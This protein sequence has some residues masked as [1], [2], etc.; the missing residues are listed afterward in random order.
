MIVVPSWLAGPAIRVLIICSSQMALM[1][2]YSGS[3]DLQFPIGTYVQLFGFC[4][5]VK[6]I[7]FVKT[8]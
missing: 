4:S 3:D 8:S 2:N 7:G 1:S 5:V 6:Q